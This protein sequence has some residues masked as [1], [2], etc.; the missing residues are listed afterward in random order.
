MEDAGS[1]VECFVAFLRSTGRLA[2]GS[3]E[4][5]K[6]ARAARRGAAFLAEHGED[7]R[8]WSPTKTL[9]DHAGIDVDEVRDIEDLQSR[10]DDAMA[11]FNALPEQ[12]RRTLMPMPGDEGYDDDLTPD[13]PRIA[14]TRS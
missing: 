11:S 4:A 9:L 8:G 14:R 5:K 2:H 6:L 13:D 12:E 3:G 1:T 10:L 7:R